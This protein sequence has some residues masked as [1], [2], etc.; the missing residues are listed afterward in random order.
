MHKTIS[1]ITFFFPYHEVSGVPVLFSRMAKHINT[2]CGITTNVIDYPDGFM[3]RTLS[4]TDVCVRHLVDGVSLHVTEETI[5]VMQAGFP[6]EFPPE[7]VIDDNCRIVYWVLHP[8]N[9]VPAFIS[10]NILGYPRLHKFFLSTVLRPLTMRLANMISN[11]VAQK[12]L[13]FMDGSTYSMTTERI[14]VKISNPI[15]LPV[16]SEDVTNDPILKS[17]RPQDTINF[18]WVG[19]L[20]DFKVYILL[21]MIGKLLR[22]ANADQ[23]ITL[24]IIGD[25]PEAKQ[26]RDAAQDSEFFKIIMLGTLSPSQVEDYLMEKVDV[27][28]S[29]GTSALE[30]ARLG[31]PTIL[32][33]YSYTPIQGDYVF[34]WLFERTGYTLADRITSDYCKAGND[35]LSIM[36]K[37]LKCEYEDITK[38]TFNYFVV[39]HSLSSVA[40]QFVTLLGETNFKFCMFN[41]KFLHKGLFRRGYDLSK[42]IYYSVKGT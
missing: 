20:C 30:A 31:I 24:H 10:R 26:V 6:Y 16:P 3:A 19:R 34:K 1:S 41:N 37:Q 42:A 36:F 14:G 18:C 22:L 39:N 9:L 12:S 35:S 5:L 17:L 25:G 2:H 32:L 23:C 15:Y 28:A 13:F 38:K 33:D 11:M 7:L 40:V 4:D 29:M 8:L 21:H 27:V